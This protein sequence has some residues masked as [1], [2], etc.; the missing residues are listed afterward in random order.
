MAVEVTAT[1]AVTEAVAP[2]EVNMVGE[3][4]VEVEK[5]AERAA[6]LMEVGTG[7]AEMVDERVEAVKEAEAAVELAEV[8]DAV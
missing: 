3:E 5:E 4:R 7:A 2:V 8:V 1:G 6:A